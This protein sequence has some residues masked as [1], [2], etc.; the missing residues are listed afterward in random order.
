MH[1]F[2]A[3]PFPSLGL[4]AN[5]LRFVEVL[6]LGAGSLNVSAYKSVLSLGCL[7]VALS[8]CIRSCVCN[9]LVDV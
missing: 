2:L 8:D 4:S 3:H 1:I 5:C 9:T 7:V 6:E